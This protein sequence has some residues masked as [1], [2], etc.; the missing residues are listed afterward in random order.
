MNTES[1]E[2]LKNIVKIPDGILSSGPQGLGVYHTNI[3][4]FIGAKTGKVFGNLN[5]KF[6]TVQK[7]T[8][9]NKEMITE[10]KNDLEE[11]HKQ[12]NSDKDE[13]L[14]T[15]QDYKNTMGTFEDFTRN[16]N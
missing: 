4:K 8:E 2:Q 14:T 3:L 1:I 12:Y 9:I 5:T 11:F 10:V 16:F 13:I 6:L 7:A 15:I